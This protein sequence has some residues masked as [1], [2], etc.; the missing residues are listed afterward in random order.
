[1]ENGGAVVGGAMGFRG[2][3]SV[4]NKG[5]VLGERV[6]TGVLRN[7]IVTSRL[8]PLPPGWS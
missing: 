2:V 3:D 7:V 5:V 6:C 4:Q 1:M 8:N